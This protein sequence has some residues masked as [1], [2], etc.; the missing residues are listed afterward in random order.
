MCLFPVLALQKQLN[1]TEAQCS[2]NEQ[3][4]R[5][6]CRLCWLVTQWPTMSH[7]F[8]SSV[9]NEWV[10]LLSWVKGK[11]IIYCHII[12]STTYS[13]MSSQQLGQEYWLED[14]RSIHIFDGEGNPQKH[15][16]NTENPCPNWDS[17]Q[18]S[19]CCEGKVLITPPKYCTKQL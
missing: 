8:D 17:N 15:G 12:H 1:E 13:E 7:P 5:G 14:W 6:E 3:K 10:G 18:Q 4:L 11:G 19:S 2:N 16:E 9:E